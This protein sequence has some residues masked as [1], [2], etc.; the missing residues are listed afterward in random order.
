[1]KQSVYE[2][3]LI[4]P[5]KRCHYKNT[6]YTAYHDKQ[7]TFLHAGLNVMRMLLKVRNSVSF[8]IINFI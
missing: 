8:T 6:D 7:G 2:N 5:L 4:K 3:N 1:M